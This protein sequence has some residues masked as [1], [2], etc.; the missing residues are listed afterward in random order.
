[1]PF[2][3]PRSAGVRTSQEFGAL[4]AELWELLRGEVEAHLAESSGAEGA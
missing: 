1:V 3:R 4:H 2:E